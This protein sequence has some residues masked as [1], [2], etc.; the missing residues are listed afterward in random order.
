MR[1]GN[2]DGLE[3]K[4][5]NEQLGFGIKGARI[6]RLLVSQARRSPGTLLGAGAVLVAGVIIGRLGDVPAVFDE[7]H[8]GSPLSIID[9]A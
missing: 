4:S 3:L 1:V 6:L 7:V 9:P 5:T 2:A 8:R